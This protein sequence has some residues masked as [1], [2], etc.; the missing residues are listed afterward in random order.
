MDMIALRPLTSLQCRESGT[1]A[2]I[3]SVNSTDLH[4][5]MAVGLFCGAKVDVLRSD[6]GK[7][8]VT[9]GRHEVALD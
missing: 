6:F 5:L 4:E 2:S 9:A 3:R 7:I 1:L 8:L